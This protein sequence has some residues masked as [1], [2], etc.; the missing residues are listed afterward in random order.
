M[1]RTLLFGR[2]LRSDEAAVERIGPLSGI[3]VL[4]F[5]ALASAAYGPEAALTVLLALGPHASALMQPISLAIIL[6]LIA[7]Y[8]SYRQ[9]IPAYPHGGGSFTVARENLGEIPGLLAACAL[10]IDYVLN[11]AVAISAGVGAV[12]SMI[13][14]LLPHTLS[15]CMG[16]L[17]L[18]TIANLRGVRSVGVLFMLP[19]YLFIFTLGTTLLVGVIKTWVEA[20][21]PRPVVSPRSH[22]MTATPAVSASTWLVLRAFA[23]G[24]TALTGVEAVS[25]AVPIFRPPTVV[26]ARRTLGLIVAVLAV[27]VAGIAF[28]SRSYRITATLPGEPGFESILSQVAGAV[29][30]HNVFYYV[31]MT[32]VLAVLAL[33]A[34]TSFADFPRVCR[35]L[36]LENYL[37]PAFA[38]R[39]RRLVYTS[40]IVLLSL[41]SGALLLAFRGLTDRLIPLFA[42][43]AFAAFTL[44]QLGMVVHWLRY[45]GRHA[46]KSLA[47]NAAGA[48]ATFS[49]LVVIAVSKFSEG[50]WLTVFVIPAL[51]LFFL[52]VRRGRERLAREAAA[53]GPIDLNGLEPPVIVIPIRRL[54]RVVRTALRFALSLSPEVF[55]VQVMSEEG[56]DY[57][58]V[59]QHWQDWVAQPARAAQLAPPELVVLGSAY[60]EFFTPLLNYVANVCEAY[61]GRRVGVIVPE[62][63]QR[64]WYNFLVRPRAWLLKTWLLLRAGPQVVIIDAPWYARD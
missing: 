60:R 53:S 64:H 23:S 16:L 33:S 49:T 45:G 54:D 55:A 51:L 61:P 4:G 34:N 30:G 15:L 41:V 40:G 3:P 9:T 56:V 42:I 47:L 18:L 7:V 20:G 22:F 57:E 31:T 39:G 43:G 5:D 13:P 14:E 36:A 37:P 6:V 46:R 19:M 44:S 1:L 48:C 12:V 24:C 32:A 27:F 21:H 35:M 59:A 63:V 8:L 58:D 10:M 62:L 26:L 17:L 28:L 2:A 25:N 38:R 50:A 29:L 52:R 11:V